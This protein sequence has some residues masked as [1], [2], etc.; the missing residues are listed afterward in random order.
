MIPVGPIR[1]IGRYFEI[2]VRIVSQLHDSFDHALVLLYAE[3]NMP[4]QKA[5]LF[6]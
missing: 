2:L 5:P 4:Q 6:C 3:N 1:D